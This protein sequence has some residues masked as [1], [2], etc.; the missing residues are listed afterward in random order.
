[1]DLNQSDDQADTAD[2][3]T[4]CE[5]FERGR[6]RIGSRQAADHSHT[7]DQLA[8]LAQIYD[9]RR[10]CLLNELYYCHHLARVSRIGLALEISIIIGSGASGVSGWFIWTTIPEIKAIWGVI[11]GIS[12]LLAAIKPA[13]HMDRRIRRYSQLFSGYREPAQW[14]RSASGGLVVP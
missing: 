6:T 10:N 3:R 9:F 4:K 5:V 8:E 1:M 14:P 11:A 2:A 12:T 13:V 7:V